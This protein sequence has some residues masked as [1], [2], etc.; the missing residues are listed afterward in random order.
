M[1]LIVLGIGILYWAFTC[2]IGTPE[3]NKARLFL[4]PVGYF[5]NVAIILFAIALIISG[6]R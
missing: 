3:Y 6:F 1:I 5:L 2:G 4:G